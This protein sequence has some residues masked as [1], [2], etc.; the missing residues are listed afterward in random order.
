MLAAP[1][2]AAPASLCLAPERT[3]FACTIGPQKLAVCSGSAAPVLRLGKGTRTTTLA[4]D[5]R[6]ARR[7]FSGGGETTVSFRKGDR[8]F[9][10]YDRTLRTE[11]GDDGRHAPDSITGLAVTRAEATIADGACNIASLNGSIEAVAQALTPAN[12]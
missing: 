11:F 1:A 3:L 10:L 9:T 12:R 2:R 4:R 6:V 5:P 8:V 7:A